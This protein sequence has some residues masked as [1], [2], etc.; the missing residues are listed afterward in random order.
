MAAPEA[1]QSTPARETLVQE[2][3]LKP[4]CGLVGEAGDQA[5]D[6]ASGVSGQPAGGVAARQEVNGLGRKE[7][8]PRLRAS[9]RAEWGQ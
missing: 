9:Q 3:S 8:D 4:D 5:S 2:R 1:R 6:M 7:A